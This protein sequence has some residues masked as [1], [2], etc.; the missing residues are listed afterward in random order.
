MKSDI[1]LDKL[2]SEYKEFKNGIDSKSYKILRKFSVFSCK[3]K[4]H[5][6]YYDIGDL[7]KFFVSFNNI[8]LLDDVKIAIS[9][10]FS[11]LL[12]FDYTNLEIFKFIDEAEKK[13]K[14]IIS[15][16]FYRSYEGILSENEFLQL[17]DKTKK[18]ES[19]L[20]LSL[21]FSG[22][23][24][25]EIENLE[26]NRIN[27]DNNTIKLEK[28][29]TKFQYSKTAFRLLK[30]SDFTKTIIENYLKEINYEKTHLNKFFG[31]LEYY[32]SEL[33][34]ICY[35]IGF[36]SVHLLIKEIN[37]LLIRRLHKRGVPFI[38]CMDYMNL[39]KTDSYF[40]AFRNNNLAFDS[41]FIMR[42]LNEA[43][44]L[45]RFKDGY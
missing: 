8:K 4:S 41:S 33:K 7:I 24:Y 6:P 1:K 35:D 3:N 44:E 32:T 20:I 37:K 30:F 31:K 26:I 39:A 5:T 2:I 19:K 28:N 40:T 23:S 29:K 21:A 45:E 12:M 14:L 38:I 15:K 43:F 36:T 22:L 27:L 18:I 10:F 25:S 9:D 34:E 13:A 11:Y 42:A 16:K 17:L